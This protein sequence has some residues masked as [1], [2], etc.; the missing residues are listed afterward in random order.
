MPERNETRQ[1]PSAPVVQPPMPAPDCASECIHTRKIFDSCQAKDCIEDLRF[2][3]TISGQGAIDS[4]ISIRAGRAELLDVSIEVKPVGLGRG[5]YEVNLSFFYRVV[6]ELSGGNCRPVAV[7]GLCVFCKRS[8]LFGSDGS[9]KTF[10][11]E[12]VFDCPYDSSLPIAVCEAV[13]PIVLSTRFA[14]I[15]ESSPF[16]DLTLPEIPAGV[17]ATFDEPLA[18]GTASIPGRR[19]YLS[20]GQFSII[21]LERDSQLLMPVYDYCMPGKECSTEK[22][23]DDPCEIFQQVDFPVSDFFPPSSSGDV[24]PVN[25]LRNSCL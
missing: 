4:A 6:M 13:D 25:R 14:E 15:G 3:P 21:R 16:Y 20:L 5:F 23:E 18:L 11:S 22:R 12:Q 19:I 17:L 2:Y 1:H 7:E 9:A 24:D 8:V 10:T